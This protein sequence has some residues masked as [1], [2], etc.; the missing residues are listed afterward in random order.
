MSNNTVIYAYDK[1]CDET[2]RAK[3][4]DVCRYNMYENIYC[5]INGEDCSRTFEFID[6]KKFTC[7]ITRYDYHVPIDTILKET[8][9]IKRTSVQEAIHNK[10]KF[11]Y[12]LSPRYFIKTIGN[13]DEN[14]LKLL[15]T[16]NLIHAINN[17]ICL[18]IIN[19]MTESSYY[20]DTHLST[21]KALCNEINLKSENVF[22]FTSN[23]YNVRCNKY[24]FN[25]IHWP[26]WECAVKRAKKYYLRHEYTHFDVQ[27]INHNAYRF[28]L[29]N[30]RPRQ[31]RY[32]LS[33]EL[34]KRNNFTF[35]NICISLDKTTVDT[36]SSLSPYLI[37][38][39]IDNS[40]QF[41]NKK[42]LSQSEQN[43]L[44]TFLSTLPLYTEFDKNEILQI[45]DTFDKINSDRKRN[46]AG[47]SNFFKC[48]HWNTFNMSMYKHC[49]IH[50]VTETL[51]EFKNTNL[52]SYIFV[53]EKTYKPIAFKAPFIVVGQPG[54]LRYL[55][56]QGYMTFSELWDESYDDEEDPEI[57]IYKVIDVI[58]KI[59]KL[60]ESE[61]IN[62]IT[63]A[64]EI[65]KYNLQI[66]NRRVS[67]LEYANIVKKFFD[68]T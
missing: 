36:L 68:F 48:N 41:F 29:L 26:Y 43:T 5:H 65:A 31:H 45:E 11:I 57:R 44:N 16:Q 33:Y 10:E 32:F 12:T 56:A 59:L 61:Y 47:T 15:L 9:N 64:K 51:A 21:L 8:F 23:P 67:E 14:F 6:G 52:S 50:I 24:K 30:A 40:Y 34:W 20:T 1:I 55:K 37:R 27:N 35:D 58:D 22:L 7:T 4:N 60:P 54:I 2:H 3:N 38:D 39:N 28:L 49:D 18:F 25:I 53:T 46:S 66:F 13:T 19:D 17:S 42:Y 63:A 62:L